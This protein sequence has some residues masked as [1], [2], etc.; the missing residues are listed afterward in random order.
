[1]E[2]G[3][4]V[5]VCEPLNLLPGLDEQAP[6][7]YADRDAPPILQ[8]YGQPGKPGLAVDCQE[9]Q[10]VVVAGIAG[11]QLAV[12]SQIRALAHPLI[13]QPEIL[14]NIIHYQGK[15]AANLMKCNSICA[16][17]MPLMPPTRAF[18]IL[19]ERHLKP[20]EAQNAHSTWPHRLQHM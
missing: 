19:S 1:M 13:S 2:A 4:D 7:W 14:D 10:I 18:N 5:T 6:A 12:R 9:V 15:Y 8:P 20:G 16:P 17:R 11:A 3:S